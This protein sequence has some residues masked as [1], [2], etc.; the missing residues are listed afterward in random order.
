MPRTMYEI[1]SE[2]NPILSRNQQAPDIKMHES[3]EMPIFGYLLNSYDQTNK[4]LS[5]Q[6]KTD[7]LWNLFVKIICSNQSTDNEK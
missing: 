7:Y 6:E 2:G 5:I 3:Q 4:D 1:D